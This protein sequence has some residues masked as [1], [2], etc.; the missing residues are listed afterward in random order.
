[1]NRFFCKFHPETQLRALHYITSYRNV[2]LKK[3]SWTRKGIQFAYCPDCDEIYKVTINIKKI[4]KKI[5]FFRD[6]LKLE[7]LH[8]KKV[9]RLNYKKEKEKLEKLMEKKYG[10]RSQ[11]RQ[12][13][14]K[15]LPVKITSL[16]DGWYYSKD[17]RFFHFIKNNR[18]NCSPSRRIN[19]NIV[20]VKKPK[21]LLQQMC[22]N[23]AYIKGIVKYRY[24]D[25]LYDKYQSRVESDRKR[26]SKVKI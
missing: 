12:F 24:A 16:E 25:T 14:P 9:L 15:P 26:R 4:Y 17:K 22:K 23:C 2:P 1:M 19:L 3:K 20:P 8:Q 18:F 10:K 5:V 11:G 6:M 7:I 21:K 13:K